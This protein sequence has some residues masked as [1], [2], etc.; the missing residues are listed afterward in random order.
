VLY[1][2]ERWGLSGY[3]FDVPNGSYRVELLFDEIFD[4]QAGKRASM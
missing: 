3:R 4:Y 1:Q 2:T